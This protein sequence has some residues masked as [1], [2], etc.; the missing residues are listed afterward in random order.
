MSRS[1]P[2]RILLFLLLIMLAATSCSLPGSAIISGNGHSPQSSLREPVTLRLAWWGGQPR[3]EY[4]LKVIELYER[5]NPHVK[6]EPEYASWDDYWRR[7]APQAAGNEL[8]DIIQMDLNYIAQYGSKG[9][10]ADLSPYIGGLLDTTHIN[11]AVIQGG[12]ISGKLYGF[13]LGVNALQI[14]YDPVLLKQATGLAELPDNWTW[15]DYSKIGAAAAKKGVYFETGLT[16]EVYFGYYLRTHGKSLYSKDGRSLGYDDDRLFEDYFT[17]TISLMLQGGSPP[18]EKM[19]MITGIDADPVVTG[20]AI[21]I[22]HWSNQYI[23]LQQTANRQLSIHHPPGPGVNEGMFLK[24]SMFFSIS[25]NS[26]RKEEAARFINFFVNDLEAN[27]L[28]NAERGVPVSALVKEELT[29]YLS[30]GQQKVFSYISWAEQHSSPI[31][32]IDPPGAAEVIELFREINERMKFRE[33]EPAD[34]ARLFRKEASLILS[35]N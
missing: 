11:E 27:K 14:N 30:P 16:P 5:Q 1:K 26:A 15:E 3:H 9:Q 22:W 31:D 2:E 34:A 4:T 17:R 33:L 21:S 20:D 29:P 24:P 28:I 18:P 7:L 25:A 23:G 8:P 10:L 13:S 35:R 19:L 6:I 12:D 32:A